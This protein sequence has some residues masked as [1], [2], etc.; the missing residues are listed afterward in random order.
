MGPPEKRRSD[1]D[2]PDVLRIAGARI[3]LGE[4][5]DVRLKI[6]ETY[7]G[8]PVP[9]PLRVIRARRPGPTVF[10]SGAL[11][12]DEING[13]GA[14]RD[15]M[16]DP[17][18]LLRGTLVLIPIMNVFGFESHN[19]YLPDR[20]DLNRCF[21]GRKEGSLGLRLAYKLFTQVFRRCDYG[22]DLHTAAIRRTNYPHVRANMSD[23][24]TADLARAFGC[25]LILAG[26]GPTGSLREA[27]RAAGCRV[28]VYEAGEAFKFEPAPVRIGVRGIRNCLHHLGLSRG[29]L[30]TPA[31][32]TI[33]RKS[34]WVRAVTGGLLRF[35]VA[36]GSV[37]DAETQI[38]SIDNLHKNELHVM[39]APVGGIVLGMTTLPAVK[40]G[41]PICHLALPRDSL[42]DIRRQIRAEPRTL[43][44]R[45]QRDL[46]TNVAVVDPPEE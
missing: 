21:P 38:A 40:P 43:H 18:R 15:L 46:A 13:V 10:V 24:V 20:R 37:V 7:T 31:Y 27:T 3:A 4:T 33:A 6:S 26:K 16:H 41:E 45:A 34:T 28:V 8:A 14:I 17:P 44:R 1:P 29:E 25:E 32:Q 12:G 30:D 22:I 11:H 23:K 19:R 35:H 39:R 42:D 2:A 9:L 5:T 36:P